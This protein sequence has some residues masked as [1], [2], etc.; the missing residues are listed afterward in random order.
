MAKITQIRFTGKAA[1]ILYEL[2][3]SGLYGKTLN[4]VVRYLV[5]EALREIA[6]KQKTGD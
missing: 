5:Y 2:L 3:D 1:D 4:E 6:R